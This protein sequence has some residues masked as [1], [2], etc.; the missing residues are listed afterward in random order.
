MNETIEKESL[1]AVTEDIFDAEQYNKPPLTAG[2]IVL[3]CFIAFFTVL[4]LL[5]IGVYLTLL[6]IARGPSE[7][8]RNMLVLS[9]RQASATKWMPQLFLDEETINEIYENSD[10][11][12][13]DVMSAEEYA[14]KNKADNETQGVVVEDEWDGASDGMVLKIE[15]GS[16]YKAY[17]LLVKDPSRVFVGTSSDNYDNATIGMDIFNVVERYDAIA[18][19][20]GGEFLDKGGV[21]T[22]A[23]PMGLTYSC[24]TCVWNEALR[25]TFIGFDSN[26]R[27]VVSESMSYAQANALGIRDAVSFQTGNVLIDSVDGNISFHYEDSNTGTAQRTAIGQREDGTVIMIV[28]DG[29]TASSIGATHNDM[30]NLMIKYGAVNAAMLDGGSSAMLYFENYFDVFPG[31]DYSR[32][33]TYQQRGLVN[34]YQAFSSPRTI[35]TFFLVRREAE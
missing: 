15:N 30:I 21:G 20:N 10:K 31:F 26:D 7:T 8:V 22:G 6:S 25:R 2:K 13:V 3:R 29:R 14:E 32:L 18:G 1:N 24:G 12:T 34:K 4:F 16:T 33:D 27:L 23:K 19:I 28:T 35:P 9:A 11:I 17:V 5:V